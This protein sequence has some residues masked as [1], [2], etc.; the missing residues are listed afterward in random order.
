MSM[1]DE[2]RRIDE[3]DAQI[4]QLLNQRAKCVCRIGEMKRQNKT[5]VYEPT[6]EQAVF[7]NVRNN[8]HGPLSHSDLVQ[9]YERIIDVMRKI[10]REQV[11]EAR[12]PQST[13][14]LEQND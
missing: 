1:E 14:E 13:T 9:L 7:E 10:Q 11:H 4:V 3:L 12:S 6:R 5:P 2:R 8:N